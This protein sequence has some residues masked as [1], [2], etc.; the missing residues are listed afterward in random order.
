MS[1]NNPR[2][3][4]ITIH[5]GKL[6]RSQSRLGSGWYITVVEIEAGGVSGFGE[7]GITYYPAAAA[8]PLVAEKLASA[9]LLGADPMRNIRLWEKMAGCVDGAYHG[10]AC[11][12]GAVSACDVALWD[13]KGKLLGQ[14]V[15]NLLGG[16]CHENLRAYANGWCYRKETPEEYAEAARAVVAAGY[17]AMK[18]DPWRYDEGEF[19]EHPAPG[20]SRTR[21]WMQIALDR[22]AAV[23]EAVGPDI[24][25]ILEAHGKFTPH[26]AIEIGRRYAEYDFLF[27]EEP[28]KTIDPE[29]MRRVADQQPIPVATGERIVREAEF[30]SYCDRQAMALAQPDVGVCGGITASAR[31]AAHAAHY[32]IGFQP[33]NSAL[34]LNTAAAYQLC[35]A[36]PNFVIQET[37]PFRPDDWYDMLEDPYEKRIVDGYL[38][39]PTTPGLGVAVNRDWLGRFD[40]LVVESSS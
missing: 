26:T 2:I 39:L 38:P 12:F 34:G 23:R 24:D 28:I 22:V 9:V 7:A 11:G 4:R 33:H 17:N 16:A 10:G 20:K 18:F 27:Y 14:P 8:A 5:H 1:L 36:Q 29:V 30:R 13:L 37:F 40:Q 6:D 35:A 3:E 21:K 32:K 31:M 15:Y 25:L 19:K